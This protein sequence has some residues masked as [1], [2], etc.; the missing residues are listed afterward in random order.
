MHPMKADLCSVVSSE[1]SAVDLR[2]S[3]EVNHAEQDESRRQKDSHQ[4]HPLWLQP[5]KRMLLF[6]RAAWLAPALSTPPEPS[7]LPHALSWHDTCPRRISQESHLESQCTGSTA[8]GRLGIVT[9]NSDPSTARTC[10]LQPPFLYST[11][12][13]FSLKCGKG[14]GGEY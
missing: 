6:A 8:E 3:N 7:D 1:A 13:W 4:G 5:E 14:Q 11:I 2:L 10:F 12:H 9:E